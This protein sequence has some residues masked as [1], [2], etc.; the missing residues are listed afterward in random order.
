MPPWDARAQFDA[1]L[2]RKRHEEFLL[3]LSGSLLAVVSALLL[4]ELL[5]VN[6]DVDTFYVVGVL[7]LAVLLAWAV[8]ARRIGREA[9][10][11]AEKA[12]GLEKEVLRIPTLYS[13][14]EEARPDVTP[15][16]MAAGAAVVG[17]IV[18]WIGLLAYAFLATHGIL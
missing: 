7:N 5:V 9:R 2:A 14:W 8:V 6:E 10:R 18:F 12:K 15:A 17:L 1:L 13:L 16:W 11:W 4:F 3:A